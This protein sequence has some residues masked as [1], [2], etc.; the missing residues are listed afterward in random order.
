V[1]ASSLLPV[2]SLAECLA[3]RQDSREHLCSC[4]QMCE[5]VPPI[6][7]LS[8]VG[9]SDGCREIVCLSPC[10]RDS[11]PSIVDAS[12][13]FAHAQ[14]VLLV[15]VLFLRWPCHSNGAAAVSCIPS[16]GWLFFFWWKVY[17]RD[18]RDPSRVHIIPVAGCVAC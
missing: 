10:A 11:L 16:M 13:F 17:S 8:F 18:L 14:I 5:K 9:L 2:L 3:F 6:A 12:C 7:G 1:C 4:C 15:F